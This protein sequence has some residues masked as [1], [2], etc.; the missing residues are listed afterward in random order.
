[1]NNQAAGQAAGPQQPK[2]HIF[3]PEQMRQLPDE[4]FSAEEKL[5]WEAGLKTLYTQ[6][7][8]FGPETPQHHEA[9]RKLLEFSKTLTQKIQAFRI[10]QAQQGGGGGDGRP[11][12]QGQQQ[13]EGSGHDPSQQPRQPPKPSAK[14]TEHVNSFPFVAPAQLQLGGP[15]AEQWIK[16]AKA[17]YGR[18]LATME[19]ATGRLQ[20]INNIM[21]KRDEEGKP[22]TPEEEKQYRDA[23]ANAEKQHGEADRFVKN[24]REQQKQ[25]AIDRGMGQQPAN[26]V[27]NGTQTPTRPH[28]SMQ[29]PA[30]PVIQQNAQAISAA[31]DVAR[32]QQRNAQSMPNPNIPQHQNSQI[33]TIKQE[34]GVGVPQ[35]NTNVH[36]RPTMGSPQ[37]ALPQS[38]GPQSAT[39]QVPRALTQ[40]QAMQTAARSYSTGTVSGTPTVMGHSHPLSQAPRVSLDLLILVH[41]NM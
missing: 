23:R 31:M 25:A 22:L 6:I 28:M 14:I 27:Q 10:Q 33:Q 32:N 36:Q 21:K 19:H 12:S 4:K 29:Q 30:N 9:K 20:M 1:M 13:G 39:S 8:T 2:T 18:A 34:A 16:E 37:S 24:F 35:I 41:A 17:K 40:Q 38:A 5:K 11:Q 3:R 26:P 15:E 7:Q